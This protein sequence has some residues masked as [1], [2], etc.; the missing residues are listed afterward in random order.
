MYEYCEAQGCARAV[1]TWQFDVHGSTNAMGAWMHRSGEPWMRLFCESTRMCE[2]VTTHKDV[3]MQREA[4]MPGAAYN[5][6]KQVTTYNYN[7]T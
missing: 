2:A 4:W 7:I 3:L 1:K 6:N 5:Q